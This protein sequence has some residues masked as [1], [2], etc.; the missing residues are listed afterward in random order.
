[1]FQKQHIDLLIAN[2]INLPTNYEHLLKLFGS[3]DVNLSLLKQR[4]Q[5]TPWVYSFNELKKMVETSGQGFSMTNF[6]QI[7]FMVPEFYIH[8]WE[9]TKSD[10]F[11]LHIEIPINAKEAAIRIKND[12]D[13]SHVEPT[14]E[15]LTS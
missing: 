10:R 2:G 9:L 5:F 15:P 1:M 7:L 6:Q 11:E 13:T 4:K 14:E 8:R 12:L 3:L